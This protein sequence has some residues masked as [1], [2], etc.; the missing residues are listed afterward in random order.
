ML[1]S[2]KIGNGSC[3]GYLFALPDSVTTR[4]RRGVSA[5]ISDCLSGEQTG[6]EF[7]TLWESSSIGVLVP[8]GRS[9]TD[10]LVIALVVLCTLAGNQYEGI[11]SASAYLS[12][13]AD[14]ALR[15]QWDPLVERSP[16]QY[17]KLAAL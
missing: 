5:S 15:Q 7:W 12:C 4:V 1:I 3:S 6:G 2:T 11:S 13:S 9:H 8:G 14:S 16:A 10:V 17:I